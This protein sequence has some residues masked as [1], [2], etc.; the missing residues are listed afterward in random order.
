LATKHYLF[1]RYLIKVCDHAG[2]LLAFAGINPVREN[3]VME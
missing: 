3:Y 1:M 2:K